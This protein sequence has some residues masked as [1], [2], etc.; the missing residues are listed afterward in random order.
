MEDQRM[1]TLDATWASSAVFDAKTSCV[2]I[3]NFSGPYETV[4]YVN[5]ESPGGCRNWAGSPVPPACSWAQWKIPGC[6]EDVFTS[7]LFQLPRYL[8]AQRRMREMLAS[9]PTERQFGPALNDALASW[10]LDAHALVSVLVYST[11]IRFDDDGAYN[12]NEDPSGYR[13][14]LIDAGTLRVAMPDVV[15]TRFYNDMS[16]RVGMR[17]DEAR[18]RRIPR[19][20]SDF[21]PTV[22]L[23]FEAVVEL[24]SANSLAEAS[25]SG[26][27]KRALLAWANYSAGRAEIPGLPI[28]GVRGGPRTLVGFPALVARAEDLLRHYVGVQYAAWQRAAADRFVL[29][30]QAMLELLPPD[31]TLA[32][33]RARRDVRAAAAL[34]RDVP[35]A[36]LRR[37]TDAMAARAQSEGSEYRAL[38]G[39]VANAIGGVAGAVW[40][41]MQIVLGALT[42]WLVKSAGA[43]TGRPVLCPAPPYIRVFAEESCTLNFETEITSRTQ[44]PAGTTGTPPNCAPVPGAAPPCPAGTTGTPP[45]C[46]PVQKASGG[47]LVI[48][49]AALLLLSR[50]LR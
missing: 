30:V 39:V 31:G 12:W 7:S 34:L 43:A 9:K 45:N 46:R 11:N 36:A 20:K 26:D 6:S 33:E 42:D 35:E 47:G 18:A 29:S 40:S 50:F 21:L 22:R 14:T 32:L 23:P 37:E 8:W 13:K 17:L 24:A 38:L 3:R 10:V 16:T 41:V 15:I 19:G 2:A 27:P 4:P 49:A 48:G 5:P 1:W 25:N 44:C 28:P